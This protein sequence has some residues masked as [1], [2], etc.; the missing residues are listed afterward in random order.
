MLMNELHKKQLLT[1]D[2]LSLLKE[3]RSLRNKVIHG[4][5]KEISDALTTRI[6]DLLW[7]IVRIFG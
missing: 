6:L 4:E 2:E 3:F 5:I 1:E 7:R